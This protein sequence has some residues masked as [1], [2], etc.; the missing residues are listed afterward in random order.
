TEL[1]PQVE[2]IVGLPFEAAIDG[3]APTAQDRRERHTRR[4]CR[5]RERRHAEAHAMSRAALRDIGRRARGETHQ[6]E[7]VA[8]YETEPARAQPRVDRGAAR[9]PG[10]EPKRSRRERIR[11]LR[12]DEEETVRTA[13]VGLR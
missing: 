7:G 6:L 12:R 10:A 5:T 8:R 13:V 3:C 1:G 2:E 9:D 11:S 4:E